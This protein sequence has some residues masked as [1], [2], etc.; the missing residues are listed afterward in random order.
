VRQY[1]EALEANRPKRGRKRTPE[2][3]R[4]KLGKLEGDI[5]AAAPV[6]RLQLIQERMDLENELS[7]M[8]N[9]VAMDS[10]EADFGALQ[11]SN[12]P[13]GWYRMS[14]VFLGIIGPRDLGIEL[15]GPVEATDI[16]N[17]A[18]LRMGN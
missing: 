13:D 4:S 14:G 1:L 10:I 12:F 16:D 3:I 18:I 17:R 6:Q 7:A 8:E 11:S 15:S 5:A 9:A 2:S